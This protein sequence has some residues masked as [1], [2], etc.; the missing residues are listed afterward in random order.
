[1]DP[2]EKFMVGERDKKHLQKLREDEL[3][4]YLYHLYHYDTDVKKEA[5]K[6]VK[7]GVEKWYIELVADMQ[8][9]LR[10]I[11][12]ERKIAV[13]CNPTS[14]VLISNFQY[15]V[16]H[17]A[18]VFNHYRLDG[19]TEEPNL[20]I[21]LNTD[22]IGVFDTSLSNEYAVLCAAIIRYRHEEGNWNDEAVYEYLEGLRQNGLEMAFRDK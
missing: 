20:W 15:Y 17:P 22:D 2:Y 3:T 13:E 9:A 7:F 5:L 1:M 12:A 16:K 18:M 21:S 19:N 4:A 14:N 6:A 8:K 11:I 10:K